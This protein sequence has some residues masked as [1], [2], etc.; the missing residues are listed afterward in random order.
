MS[1]QLSVALTTARVFLNDTPKAVW[2]DAQ[3]IPIA[4]EAHRELQSKLWE[5]GSPVVRAQSADIT[6]TAGSTSITFAGPPTLP[7]DLLTPFRLIERATTDILPAAV[8][9][10]EQTFIPTI[11][12]TG[13]LQYWAWI[14]EAIQLLGATADRKVVIFYRKLIPIPALTTDPLGILHA[15]QFVGPR[16]AAIAHLSLGNKTAY[17][18]IMPE[19]T[20]KLNM[21][22]AAQRGQQTPPIKP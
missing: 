12:Q 13:I 16:T 7:A 22:V 20:M 9:M 5:V 4:Q 17:D 6:V 10:T 8:E 11:A 18:S 21:V 19:S 14:D 15:E 3:L 2:T 1:Q